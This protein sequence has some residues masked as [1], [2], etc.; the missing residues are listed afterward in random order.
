MIYIAGIL[1][2]DRRSQKEIAKIALVPESTIR[3]RYL[4]IA[5]GLAL[6]KD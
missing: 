5:R 3:N 6:K 4:T 2:N 1:E